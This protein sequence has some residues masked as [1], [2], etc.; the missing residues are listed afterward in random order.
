MQKFAARS[1][2]LA[3]QCAEDSA[4]ACAAATTAELGRTFG[5]LNEHKSLSTKGHLEGL[6]GTATNHRLEAAARVGLELHLH[7]SGPHDD[8]L[9][10][11]EGGSARNVEHDG[12]AIGGDGLSLIHI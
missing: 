6:T 10:V 7:S 4:A 2:R 1:C 5:W 8:S 11:A 9:S 3:A 12:R